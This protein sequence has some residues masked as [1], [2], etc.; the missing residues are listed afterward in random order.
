MEFA[1]NILKA[2]SDGNRLRVVMALTGNEKLCVCEITEMLGLAMG[3]VS[4][5]MSV[6]QKARL[7]KSRKNGRW[8]YYSLS[9]EFPAP[10]LEWLKE[11]AGKNSEVIMDRERLLGI[12]AR[13]EA[14]GCKPK[15][16]VC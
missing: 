7:V 9:E 3:T 12:L 6:L 16:R 1:L 15:K 13:G 10:L 11:K 2:V 5:H 4:R 14:E 8:V